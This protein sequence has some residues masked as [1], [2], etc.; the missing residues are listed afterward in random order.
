MKS[1]FTRPLFINPQAYLTIPELSYIQ[2]ATPFDFTEDS[3]SFVIN[4]SGRIEGKLLKTSNDY[5]LHLDLYSIDGNCVLGEFY[6]NNSELNTDNFNLTQSKNIITLQ[7]G[8]Q[9][10]GNI[11]Y[12]GLIAAWSAKGKSNDDKDRAILKDLT[13]N[14]HD[15][16]LNGFAFSK[17][18]GYGGYKTN[19][20]NWKYNKNSAVILSSANKFI[21]Y[22]TTEIATH[23]WDYVSNPPLGT[24]HR[25]SFKLKISG[26]NED[27]VIYYRYSDG[28]DFS[29]AHERILLYN[30]I[31]I[32]PEINAEIVTEKL[33]YT[34][35]FEIY[36]QNILDKEITFEILPEYPDALVF[37]GV[38]DYGIN[39]NVPIL[40]DFTVIAKRKTFK[41][42]TSEQKS[43]FISKMLMMG[44]G[45]FAI[46][47]AWTYN[48]VIN[49]GANNIINY[50]DNDITFVTKNNYNEQ[51]I[52]S[53]SFV[54]NQGI[55]I[56]AIR[57][58]HTVRWKGAIY[59]VYLFDRSLDEQE[60]KSFI[61]K[62]IDPEYLFPSEIPTPDCY[63][64]F[65]KGSNDDET[66]DTI[67]DYSG[68]GNDAVA[69]NFAWSGMSGYGGYVTNFH[70]TKDNTITADIQNNKLNVTN[71]T[72]N[73]KFAYV[74]VHAFPDIIN[75]SYKIQ[76][77]G[78]K[79]TMNLVYRYYDKN[80]KRKEINIPKD[81]VYQIPSGYG[82]QGIEIVDHSG[83]NVS[84][85]TGEC[86]LIIEMIPEYPGALIFDGVDDYI[87]LDAFDSGF[88]TMFMVC[89]PFVLNKMLYDQRT[90]G[91]KNDFALYLE[92]LNN[93]AYN[94]RNTNGTY[95]NNKFNS[96]LIKNTLNK[97]QLIMVKSKLTEKYKPVIGSNQSH[98]NFF[99]NMALYKFLGFKEAL[100]EEQIQAVIKK[101]NLLDGVDEIEVS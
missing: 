86:N 10:S 90:L 20:L 21:M 44:T 101:Y 79:D 80:R 16:T 28:E 75:N 68:N 22:N 66:R 7:F 30:G 25:P 50:I 31:N 11:T 67:K 19:M 39:E 65:S 60:I 72:G 59:S 97:K 53:G 62:Y 6:L 1:I 87:S 33:P 78:L 37:D 56:G 29:V 36:S 9:S 98:N 43:P 15:I 45:A 89:N 54:D 76:V 35:L 23:F 94:D 71:I 61:R 2:M 49:F 5:I 48:N 70:N 91:A 83:F 57:P 88:K 8:E 52:I 77:N 27:E 69:H 4:T 47:G 26:L 46:E 24:I 96:Y 85:F 82:V 42:E 58:S 17:M 73:G 41:D 32:F 40:T 74:W 99:A 81:G 34:T 51:S 14:G 55:C 3:Y 64:D 93:V 95:I 63:Y 92:N 84:N 12:P 13:G 100:T 38:D 18:S